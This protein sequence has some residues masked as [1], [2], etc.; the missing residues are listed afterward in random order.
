MLSSAKAQ[1]LQAKAALDRTASDSRRMIELAQAG[2]Q[3]ERSGCNGNQ[4]ASGASDCAGAA[5]IGEGGGSELELRYSP[6][7]ASQCGES[8]VQATEADLK[9]AVAQKNQAAVRLGYT[10]VYAP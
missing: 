8:T 1:L 6:H 7:P 9:N 10:N 2:V 4:P 3:S 5:G